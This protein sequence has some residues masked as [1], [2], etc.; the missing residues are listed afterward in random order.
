MIRCT[1]DGGFRGCFKVGKLFIRWLGE[2]S[3]EADGQP[4][5]IVQSLPE[6]PLDNGNYPAWRFGCAS[7][8]GTVFQMLAGFV[9]QH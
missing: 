6:C 4:Y 3:L 5:R 7:V 8:V 9:C 1:P 2:A